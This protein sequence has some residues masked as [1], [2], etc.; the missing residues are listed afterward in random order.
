MGEQGP[1]GAG[2][3]SSFLSGDDALVLTTVTVVAGLLRFYRLS[4]PRSEMFDEVYYA[5]DACFYTFG[6]ADLCDAEAPPTEVHP[7]LG[8]W[9]LAAGI[10]LFGYDAFGWRVVAALAGALTVA[11]LFLLARRV[12]RS[13]AGAT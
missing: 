7:P 1:S 3:R 4:D 10:R 2:R 11:L 5:K 13:T 6:T 8:K 12:L 9:L